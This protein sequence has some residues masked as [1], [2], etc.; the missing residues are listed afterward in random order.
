MYTLS[1]MNN[2]N[3]A[4]HQQG[5]PSAPETKIETVQSIAEKLEKVAEQISKVTSE[6]RE[7][8]EQLR[9]PGTE[10]KLKALRNVFDLLTDE[11]TAL[12]QNLNTMQYEEARLVREKEV[13]GDKK[14]IVQKNNDPDNTDPY[15]FEP[16]DKRARGDVKMMEGK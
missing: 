13:A 3:N 9:G 10:G 6:I 7:M 16:V 4:P 2:F 14:F 5:Q 12:H 15:A 11:E 8:N 1:Y